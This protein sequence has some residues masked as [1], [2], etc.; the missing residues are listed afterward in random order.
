M[1]AMLLLLLGLPLAG[2][3]LDH[4]GLRVGVLV[5]VPFLL[6]IGVL[7]MLNRR[8]GEEEDWGK[9]HFPD[10]DDDDEDHYLM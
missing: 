9:E 4:P 1:R 10:S 2:C 7:W 5:L 6:L 8:P 3:S